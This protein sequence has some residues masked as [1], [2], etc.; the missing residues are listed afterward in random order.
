MIPLMEGRTRSGRGGHNPAVDG[1]LDVP[2]K[3]NIQTGRRGC[4]PSQKEKNNGNYR[5]KV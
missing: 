5:R 2:Q 1:V 3:I 4:R